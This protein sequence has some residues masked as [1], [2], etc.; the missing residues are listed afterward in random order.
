M[1]LEG[2]AGALVVTHVAGVHDASVL[3]VNVV[4]QPS[5]S[6]HKTKNFKLSS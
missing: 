2:A 5:R 4:L 6:G 1:L 3:G